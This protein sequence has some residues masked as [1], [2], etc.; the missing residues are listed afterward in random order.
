MGKTGYFNKL[1]FVSYQ[2]TGVHVNVLIQTVQSAD[3][4]FIHWAKGV[5]IRRPPMYTHLGLQALITI[6]TPVSLGMPNGPF[7][8][9]DRVGTEKQKF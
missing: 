9:E 3:Y 4:S 1:I 8:T 2:L 5:T 6:S 7:V